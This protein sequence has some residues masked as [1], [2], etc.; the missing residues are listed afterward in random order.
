MMKPN[1]D[2]MIIMMRK[3]L[4]VILIAGLIGLCGVPWVYGQD[5]EMVID[6]AD[7]YARDQRAA[8]M[9][10]HELHMDLLA[11]LDCHHDYDQGKNIL[12]EDELEEGN[13]AIRCGS[14][15]DADATPNLRHAYHFQ[16]VGCHR[17]ARINGE[18][19][20]PELCGECHVK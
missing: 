7:A 4:P 15:H 18:A 12:D 14:C 20:G 8:V 11:C 2:S 1:L 16:C 5:A 9:F 6:N 10:S 19:T 3:S 13:P 17:Q